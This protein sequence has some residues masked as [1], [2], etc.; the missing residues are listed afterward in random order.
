MEGAVGIGIDP[1]DVAILREMYRTRRVTV[2]G[3]D[4]RL[5]VTYLARHLKTSRA[6]ITRRLALWSRSG[7]LRRFD[8][9]PNPALLH[10]RGWTVNVRVADR[11]EKPKVLERLGAVDG[12]VSAVEFLGEWLSVQFVAPDDAASARRVELLRH[13]QGVAEVDR[14][15]A[16]REFEPTAPLSP[17][18]LRIVKALRDRPRG[19]LTE[20]ARAVG[21]SMR[22]MTTR[23]ERLVDGWAVWFVPVFDFT[24]LPVPIVNLNVWLSDP[25]AADRVV[26]TVMAKFPWT[27]EFGWGGLGPTVRDDYLVLFVTLPSTGAIEDLERLVRGIPGTRE[28]EPVV[29]LRTHSFPEWFN[30]LLA[31]LSPAAAPAPTRAGPRRRAVRG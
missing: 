3:I 6:R 21:I 7:F 22:T 2:A 15:A 17:L 26:R 31:Q 25:A 30:G 8:V 10:L 5:N 11:L 27:L 4:P 14:P 20:I 9:W 12:V 16:W 18:D 28:T 23:Y 1:L 24:Q 13:L 19:T 29:M